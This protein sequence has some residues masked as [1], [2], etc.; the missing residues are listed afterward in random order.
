MPDENKIALLVDSPGILVSK[1]KI[2]IE[3]IVG[4][5]S[6]YGEIH[7]KHIYLLEDFFRDQAKKS[8]LDHLDNLGFEKTLSKNPHINLAIDATEIITTQD[9]TNILAIA[10]RNKHI[11]PLFHK[12]MHYPG[13]ETMTIYTTV[14]GDNFEC[15]NNSTQHQIDM[16]NYR[17]RSI[18]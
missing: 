6:E 9:D 18:S 7:I 14:A 16:C 11:L 3:D 4:A 13:I 5:V 12:A 8:Y 2:K 1:F 15:F 17:R 10:S